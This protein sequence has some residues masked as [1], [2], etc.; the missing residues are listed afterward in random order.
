MSWITL[1]L[2]LISVLLNASAQVFLRKAASGLGYQA[3]QLDHLVA[4]FT[5][6][7]IN[8]FLLIGMCCYVLSIGIWIGVLA[9]IEVSIAYPFLS[10]G[11]LVVMAAGFFFLGEN[12]TLLRVAGVILICAGLI[13]IS[14][15]A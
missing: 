2:I 7:A 3:M 9:R 10:I 14:Q 13:C 1:S 8:P 6:L 11:Y 12:V 5:A 15:S 4:T